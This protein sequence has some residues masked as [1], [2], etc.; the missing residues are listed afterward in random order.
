M[1]LFLGSVV[2]DGGGEQS[3]YKCGLTET[4]FTTDHQG[5]VGPFARDDFMLLVWQVG[6][7]NAV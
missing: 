7:A 6:D 3:I 2:L 5:K 4:R 1:S